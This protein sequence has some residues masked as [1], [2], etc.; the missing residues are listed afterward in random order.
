MLLCQQEEE[1]AANA[2]AARADKHQRSELLRA[3]HISRIRAKAGDET[4]KVEEVSFIN[5]LNNEGKK[6][7]LQQR[8]EDGEQGMGRPLQSLQSRLSR[9][10]SVRVSD[11]Y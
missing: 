5:A 10:V 3:A 9:T 6:A 2:A 11:S 1:G 7:D 4:R 8:L